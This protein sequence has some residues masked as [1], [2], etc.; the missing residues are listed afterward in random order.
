MGKI[1]AVPASMPLLLFG[2][3]WAQ[4]KYPRTSP[5]QP[6]SLPPELGF[7]MI[8][9]FGVLALIFLAAMVL[10]AI[11]Q[12]KIFE[13]AGQPGWACLIP[14]YNVVVLLR[15]AERPEWWLLLM[16]V[17]LV[18]IGV[19]VLISLDLARRF[20]KEEVF[21][22]GLVLLPFVFYPILGFGDAQYAPEGRC[23]PPGRQDAY[24]SPQ[25]RY[26]NQGKERSQ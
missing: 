16:F 12:W 6:D 4:G 22:V 2:T 18:N 10:M 1:R 26:N 15:I 24:G 7:F 25:Q 13:K 5:A 3:A 14:V 11:A 17:P 8:G 19:A 21:A 23:G 9:A 20:G